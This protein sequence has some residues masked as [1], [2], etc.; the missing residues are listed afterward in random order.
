MAYDLRGLFETIKREVKAKPHSSLDIL[1]KDLRVSRNTI[2]KAV[3]VTTK[4][5]FHQFRIQC[6][7][8][9]ALELLTASP[10]KSIK[11]VAFDLGFNSARSFERFAKCSTGRSPTELRKHPPSR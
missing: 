4:Q 11:E 9:S 8:V 7:L 2:K 3:R 10:G 6:M 1:A 5:S